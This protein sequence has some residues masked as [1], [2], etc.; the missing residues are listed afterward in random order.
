MTK[1]IKFAKRQDT[2]ANIPGGIVAYWASEATISDFKHQKIGDY[3]NVR[4]GI[5]T[6]DNDKYLRFWFEVN[7]GNDCWK[8]CKKGGTFRKW[9]GNNEYVVFWKDDGLAIKTSLDEKGRVKARLGGVEHAFEKGLEMSRITTGSVGF[10]FSEGG[11]VFESSTNDIFF[12]KDYSDY[13]PLLGYCNSKVCNS[14]LDLMN[15]TINVMPEDV[16]N[17]PF[18]PDFHGEDVVR[19]DVRKNIE[20]SKKDWDSFETS[21]DFRRH[22]LIDGGNNMGTLLAVKFDEW[23]KVCQ[24]RF[25]SL[26]KNEEE[27]N[28]IFIDVYG[29]AGELEPSVSD[30]EVTVRLADR[31]REIKSLLSYF[32]GLNMGRYSL[33]SDGLIYAGGLWDSTKYVSVQPNRN[34]IEVINSDFFGDESLDNKCISLIRKIYG[35]DTFENNL[36]FV[37]DAIGGKGS[38]RE[39]IGSYFLNEFYQDHLKVYQK[40]PIYWLFD[41]GKKNSFK[42]FVYIHRYSSD[43][44]ATLRTDYIL[45]LLDR[46]NSRIDFLTKELV[47][48]SGNEASKTTKELERL[49]GQFQELSEYEP[50][51]HHLADQH[52]E[53]NLDDGVKSNYE[54][55]ADV[56]APLK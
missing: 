52:I 38:P 13:Y 25:A 49:K 39:V 18:I 50:K 34:G 27:V 22:P 26:K 36:S 2:F 28:S 7:R 30:D 53:L 41:A 42:A 54:K 11:F 5:S 46:Y 51:V 10:R 8:P 14:F 21:W 35:D 32:V 29:L 3:F 33:D 40:R 45:P 55:L 19:E 9:Y 47:T 56:L 20:L 37:A 1:Q 15:P 44:L 48:L 23:G 31:N 17:I 16:R 43:T 24:E 12:D 4:N 6:G